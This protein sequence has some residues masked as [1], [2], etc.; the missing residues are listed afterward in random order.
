MGGFLDTKRRPR[1]QW[2][3]LSAIYQS[4]YGADLIAQ[5]DLLAVEG[6]R[7]AQSGNTVVPG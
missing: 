3:Q 4:L 5:R 6:R 1:T 7:L 2:G